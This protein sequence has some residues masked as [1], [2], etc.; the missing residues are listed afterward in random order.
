MKQSRLLRVAALAL[1]AV[2][3][4]GQGFRGGGRGFRSYDTI[5]KARELESG[6]TGT[7]MWTNAAAFEKDVWTFARVRYSS[8]Y[9]G[10]RFGRGGWAVDIPDSDLNLSWRVQ[11]MT[12]MK[13]DPEGRVVELTDSDLFKFP[14]LY[15]VEPGALRFTDQEV[16]AF[17]NY[18]LN[19]GFAMFDDFW[20]DSA[21]MN[22]LNELKRVF[23]ERDFVELDM[24][25]PIFHAVF[26]LKLTK[27]QMQVPN[28][29]IGE[30][31]QRTDITWEERH[32]G[33]T[34]NVHFKATFDD[35]GRPMVFLAHNTDN[36]DGWERE[37]EYKYYFEQFSEKK[38]YPLGINL[39]FYSMT[40]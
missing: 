36:G 4:V 12:S 27:N 30:A 25:H 35:K 21:L 11:Q 18:L 38:A 17:R 9:G 39:L 10:S 13:V 37:G 34:R 8:G 3:A 22:V 40:H 28:F 31:S 20:G 33:D 19:G 1:I 15:F 16:V 7:P 6:S 2:V 29:R 23:P 5:K 32:D 26:D 24:S 14:W